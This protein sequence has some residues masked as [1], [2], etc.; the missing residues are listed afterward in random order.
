MM[1][2][3]S[4]LDDDVSDEIVTTT[5]DLEE[6]KPA[7]WFA[8]EFDLSESE[9]RQY[10]EKWAQTDHLTRGQG[11]DQTSLYGQSTTFPLEPVTTVLREEDISEP[12]PPSWF[13][14]KVEEHESMMSDKF[15]ELPDDVDLPELEQ[16]SVSTDRPG[17]SEALVHGALQSLIQTGNAKRYTRGEQDCFAPPHVD[18]QS[19][20]I[21]LHETQYDEQKLVFPDGSADY[22]DLTESDRCTIARPHD[23]PTVAVFVDN[24]LSFTIEEDADERLS[25]FAISDAGFIAYHSG[26]HRQRVF[27]IRTFEGDILLQEEVEV[28]RSPTA[29][30]DGNYVAFWK[31]TDH[32]V[33]CYDVTEQTEVGQFDTETLR[34]TNIGVEGT[35]RN[36]DNCF[37]ISDTY[38]PGT[39][40]VLGYISTAGELIETT[41]GVT[42]DSSME[43]D[44]PSDSEILDDIMSEFDQH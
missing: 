21:K 26:A 8:A 19:E 32:T 12:K 14:E 5:Y 16:S 7:S 3:E 37:A 10:L 40:E 22:V 20:T 29:T 24:D 4:E 38:G 18:A 33:R 44:G 35:T 17:E 28:A 36:G 13:V 34:K 27:N 31:L 15:E 23:K 2:D 6:P 11:S 9:A 39:D 30:P 41:D 43:D 1:S 25:G 42:A